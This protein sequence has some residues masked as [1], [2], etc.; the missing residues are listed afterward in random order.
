MQLLERALMR[1]AKRMD[2]IEDL[3]KVLQLA[4]AVVG[5]IAG[6]WLFIQFRTERERSEL[7]ALKLQISK[8]VTDVNQAGIDLKKASIDLAKQQSKRIEPQVVFRVSPI[9]PQEFAVSFEITVTNKSDTPVTIHRNVVNVYIGRA[10]RADTSGLARPINDPP[11]VDSAVNWGAPVHR[12]EYL[13]SL[14]DGC[15]TG[16]FEPGEW[17]KWDYSYLIRARVGQWLAIR[18]DLSVDQGDATKTKNLTITKY[19]YLKPGNVWSCQH[20][21]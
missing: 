6:A 1:P 9:A 21:V 11:D 5:A 14:H 16:R 4:I 15:N 19:C 3:T 17:S 13:E 2:V 10:Q 8:A 12:A 20:G 18:S 7:E